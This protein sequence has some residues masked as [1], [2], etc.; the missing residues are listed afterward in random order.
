MVG[1]IQRA[2]NLAQSGQISNPKLQPLSLPKTGF[3]YYAGFSEAFVRSVMESG[4]TDGVR[5]ILDPWNGV[6]TTTSVARKYGFDSIGLDLNPVAVLVATASL[7]RPSDVCHVYE[8][9]G[10][11]CS[12]VSAPD[13]PLS[14]WLFPGTAGLARVM[15][16]KVLDSLPVTAEGGRQDPLQGV[17]PPWAAFAVMAV[18]LACKES[19]SGDALSNPTWVRPSPQRGV[20]DHEFRA[21]VGRHI[22]RLVGTL[23]QESDAARVEILLGD[24]RALP[25]EA[26]TVDFVITSPPYCTRLDYIVSTSVELATL[27]LIFRGQSYKELR[28][29]MLGTPLS[30]RRLSPPLPDPRWG[31]SAVD[32]LLSVRGHSSKDSSGYYYKSYFQYISDMF[33]SFSELRRVLRRG[34]GGLLVVQDSYYKDIHVD[35]PRVFVD[36]AESIGMSA[37][38]ISQFPGRR[39]M[40][41]MNSRARKYKERRS[42]FETVIAVERGV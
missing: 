10:G 1:F 33:K 19:S 3:K 13:D 26:G 14:M 7:A 5:Q 31:S 11:C 42:Y 35:L 20:V 39:V 30:R 29:E 25:L 9:L 27:G 15:V 24:S 38:V 4:L 22:E 6:G 32:L 16:N 37:S 23:Y 17:L 8:L 36:M 34:G 18:M 12:T 2:K 21:R 41:T 28:R 40:T